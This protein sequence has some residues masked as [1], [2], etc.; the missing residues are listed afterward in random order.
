MYAGGFG[1]QLGVGVVTVVTTTT[2]YLTWAFAVLSGSLA[3]GLAIGLVFGAARALPML[4][5]ASAD[6]PAAVR[7]AL[8]RFNGWAPAARK[9]STAATAI[10]PVLALVF[11]WGSS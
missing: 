8:R 3:G 4:L 9:A 11:V 5:V 1:L 7:A 10:V 2:V 6:T